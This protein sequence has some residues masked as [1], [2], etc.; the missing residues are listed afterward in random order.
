MTIT[1]YGFKNKIEIDM[2][3]SVIAKFQKTLPRFDEFFPNFFIY[4]LN[5]VNVNPHGTSMWYA[6]NDGG[7]SCTFG[8]RAFF[9]GRQS[10]KRFPRTYFTSEQLIAHE[11]AHTVNYKCKITD[12]ATHYIDNRR[13]GFVARSSEYPSEVITDAVANYCLGML[14]TSDGYFDQVLEKIEECYL[15]L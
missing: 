8:H 6:R 14:D 1:L 13:L 3:S 15:P 11:L 4:R 9:T 12:F 7:L 5:Q 2:V 10:V